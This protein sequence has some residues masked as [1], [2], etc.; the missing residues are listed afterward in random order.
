MYAH[1]V[2]EDLKFF[3]KIRRNNKAHDKLLDFHTE[4]LIISIK[5]SLK[6]NVHDVKSM[7][8]MFY[9]DVGSQLFL[10]PESKY[11]RMPFKKIWVDWIRNDDEVIKTGDVKIL[12]RG[13][14]VDEILPNMIAVFVFNF[15]EDKFLLSQ[16]GFD[17][18]RW[19]TP[20]YGSI[21]SIGTTFKENKNLMDFVKLYNLE[22]DKWIDGNVNF[23]ALS[24]YYVVNKLD[25][26]RI[27]EEDGPDITVLNSLLKLLNCKNIS[28]EKYYPSEKLNKS[29][30]MLGKQPLFTY[31]TLVVNPMSEK[32]RSNAEHEP[33]GIKQRLHFCRGHFK[34]YTEQNKLFGKHTGL[35]WWQPMVRGNKELGLVHKDYE[36]RAA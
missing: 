3:T 36:V 16:Y 11:Q 24:K 9:K 23:F 27:M 18:S 8:E 5:D 32:K 17:K 26:K 14:L 34:E 22:V 25:S 2:I 33:T 28:T 30:K 1:Q 12:K 7:Y 31:H 15:L 19:I 20:F 6:F 29:R 21:F 4:S 35:Y 10:G 13:L